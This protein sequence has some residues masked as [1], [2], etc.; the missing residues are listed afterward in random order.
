M[1]PK[2]VLT[3]ESSESFF[4]HRELSPAMKVP[5]VTVQEDIS[6]A[7]HPG[8]CQKVPLISGILEFIKF[9]IEQTG[10]IYLQIGQ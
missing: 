1:Y 6:E 5:E 8:S 7:E 3:T 9:R 2:C 4:R 10:I